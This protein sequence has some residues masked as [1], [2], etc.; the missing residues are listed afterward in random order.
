[1]SDGVDIPVD[2]I[3][4]V[5]RW[6]HDAGAGIMQLALTDCADGK[7]KLLAVIIG[8]EDAREAGEYLEALAAK[9]VKKGRHP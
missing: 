3:H 7:D 1:M 4:T 8:S 9:S 2:A 5:I 6:A